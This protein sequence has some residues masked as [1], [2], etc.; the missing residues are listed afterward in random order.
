MDSL[1]G[2]KYFSTLDL[3]SDFFQIKIE[4]SSRQYTVFT[5]KNG[6]FQFKRMPFGLSNNPSTFSRIMQYVLQDLNWRICVNYI[7]DIIVYSKTL[8]DHLMH[9]KIIFD[10]LNQHNLKLNPKKC[11]FAKTKIDFLGHTISADGIRPNND[12][13]KVIQQHPTPK[14]KKQLKSFLG[15]VN[16]YRK[17]IPNVSRITEPLNRL[18]RKNVNFEWCNKCSESFDKLKELLTTAPILAFPNFDLDFQLSV[19][20][21]QTSIGFILSQQQDGCERIIACSGRSLNSHERNYSI[22]ELE[23]L[24]VVTGISHFHVYLY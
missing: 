7:D 20:A 13:V 10:R 4:E 3:K 14:T 19:D 8:E 9:L 12:K 6:L 23:A 15:L 21:C 11:N 24:A 16:Y 17:Y 22:N 1:G 18:L 5:C 2:A